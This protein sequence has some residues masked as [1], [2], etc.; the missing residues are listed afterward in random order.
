VKNA[1]HFWIVVGLVA[2]VDLPLSLTAGSQDRVAIPANHPLA[3]TANWQ[4]APAD[5]QLHLMA[6]L[7]LGHP[8]EL[9]ALKE[10]LQQPGSGAYHKWLSGAEFARRFGATDAHLRSVVGWLKASG[11]TIDSADRRTREV[12]FSGSV[13]QV[14]QALAVALVSK[15][16]QY[17]NVSD[18][19]VPAHL[20]GTI[21][22]FFGLN[23][24]RPSPVASAAA[25]SDRP[26][27]APMATISGSSELHFSPE[28]F[29]L[30]YSEPNP[31]GAGANG[32]TGTNDCIALLENATLITLPSPAPSPASS[33]VDVFSTQFGLPLSNLQII[34]TDQAVAP[35][36]PS[37]NEPQLD[38]E[39]AHAVAPNTPIS[40]YVA[41]IPN[42]TT[43]AFDT[44]SLAVS[45]NTC[46]VIS[47][48]IDD[49]GADCPDLAQIQAYAETDSQA[50]VQGQTLF[51][52]S[53]DYGS[54]YPCGQPASGLQPSIEESSASSD[55]TVAGGTQFNPVY[56]VNGNDTSVLAP[57][58][59][60]VWQTP[61]PL[62]PVPT[63]TPAPQ[64]GTSGGGIS[65]VFPVPSWQATIVPYG[66]TQSLQMRGVPDV[67]IAAS[68]SEPGYW[69]ATTTAISCMN[70]PT[71]TCFIGDGGTSASSPIWAGISRLIAQS[72]GT[73][74]LGNINSRLYQLA[75]AGSLA[76]VDVSQVGNNCTYDNC[77]AFP[78]Y[79]VGPGYDL[80]TG[81]G[82][83]NIQELIAA[84]QP[85]PTSTPTASATATATATSTATATP[86]TTPIGP[87]PT[88]APT[89]AAQASA[90]TIVVKGTPGQTIA[91]GR[92]SI[93]N[94]SYTTETVRSVSVTLSNPALFVGLMMTG[95]LQNGSSQTAVTGSI[96]TKTAFTFSP[97]LTLSAA[98]EAQFALSARLSSGVARA[99]NGVR[100][101]GLPTHHRSRQGLPL[102][103]PLEFLGI[104]LVAVPGRRRRVA[105]VI[106]ALI[107]LSQVGCN[108]GSSSPGAS[109]LGS[110]QQQVPADGVSITTTQ[111]VVNLQGLP[112]TLSEIRLLN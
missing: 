68:S 39:W 62:G 71:P 40:L 16:E 37:D 50:V 90:M 94:T 18:P 19:R 30:F 98:A 105:L 88:P 9:R 78:G 110:S 83:P 3:N 14:Q 1:A 103:L 36:Q 101:S 61:V 56:D 66:L 72:L 91:G 12:R 63:P 4:S 29:W 45:Q 77:D 79:Q 87:I 112:I 2:L 99:T 108:G 53:G 65:V 100:Y 59:E 70:S 21:T 106:A 51:H 15:G 84:F 35:S 57:G 7:A 67:S 69:I 92:L 32:G 102:G 6:V 60:Q 55:V 17:T 13:A 44:L 43:A 41:T 26:V 109:V 107:V 80:G 47:S 22:A 34:P 54:F 58:L 42:S 10:Q 95:T 89:P 38:T 20:A 86:T 48:S 31:T 82:S 81:L 104:G 46:G 23:N 11:F 52:S 73:T 111:G 25:P 97:P 76:L 93:T 24:L 64:K 96:G 49:T 85:S 8:D 27:P 33:I 28:D 5:L 74:R 75:A